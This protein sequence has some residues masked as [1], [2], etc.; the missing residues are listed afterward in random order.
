MNARKYENYVAFVN[1]LSVPN[2]ALLPMLD[3]PSKAKIKRIIFDSDFADVPEETRLVC[4]SAL[5]EYSLYK[6]VYVALP[7]SER[8]FIVK[9]AEFKLA[10][11]NSIVNAAKLEEVKQFLAS[12]DA[13]LLT[14]GVQA[15]PSS[16]LDYIRA[17]KWRV[18]LTGTVKHPVYSGYQLITNGI[19]RFLVIE[20]LGVIQ[21]NAQDEDRK[22]ERR[23]LAGLPDTS[24]L[25]RKQ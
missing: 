5:W 21:M 2:K 23:S 13:L 8:N 22:E 15:Y 16:M 7:D 14:K 9:L 12:T 4:C 20:G 25:T 17:K 10:Q 11:Y 24:K 6:Q 19:R 18:A 1:E 3:V